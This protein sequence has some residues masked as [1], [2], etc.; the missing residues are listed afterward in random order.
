VNVKRIAVIIIFCGFAF[1]QASETVL[2]SFGSNNFDGRDPNG[3]VTFDS[4]G[5]IFGTTPA[6]GTNGQGTV[7]E[8]QPSA[9]GWTETVIYNFCSV[10]YPTCYNGRVSTSK[11]LIDSSGNLFGT[12]GA[13]GNAGADCQAESGGIVFELSPPLSPSGSWTETVLWNFDGG[14]GCGPNGNLIVDALGDLYGTTMTGGEANRGTVFELSPTASGWT[15]T[16]L[17]SFCPKGASV[18]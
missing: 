8:L 2:Y 5:R 16:V 15:E 9:N 6:G 11:L 10:G 12:T 7:F 13:G 4:S 3:G 17:Y 18:S 1:G 14:G